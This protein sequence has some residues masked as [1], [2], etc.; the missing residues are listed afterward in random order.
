M[1]NFVLLGCTIWVADNSFP[2]NNSL[3]CIAVYLQLI[4]KI[5]ARFE[6]KN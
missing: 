1:W 3:S 4:N 6:E 2:V 5:W